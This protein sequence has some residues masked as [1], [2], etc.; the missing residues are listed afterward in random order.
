MSDGITKPHNGHKPIDLRT[1]PICYLCGGSWALRDSVN[2]KP[3]VECDGC[4]FTSYALFDTV[5]W[6]ARRW[7]P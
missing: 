7:T 2:D 5:V 1:H 4:E 6:D 3:V